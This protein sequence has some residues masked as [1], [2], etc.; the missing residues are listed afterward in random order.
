MHA[1]VKG[2]VQPHLGT[3]ARKRVIHVF[4]QSAARSSMRKVTIS[5]T[6]TARTP[7]CGS[8]SRRGRPPAQAAPQ[9]VWKKRTA[10]IRTASTSCAH[11]SKGDTYRVSDARAAACDHAHFALEAGHDRFGVPGMVF[12]WP[13]PHQILSFR[14][15]AGNCKG[16]GSMQGLG[17]AGSSDCWTPPCHMFS[18]S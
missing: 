4:L 10:P 8:K 13:W 5:S 7:V 17:L 14:H 2:A 12:V 9:S 3:H 18:Q 11:D 1:R 16:M 6:S 15:T